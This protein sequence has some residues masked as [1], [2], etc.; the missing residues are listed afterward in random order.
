MS[1]EKIHAMII[2]VSR[3]QLWDKVVLSHM[4]VWQQKN[5]YLIK[6]DEILYILKTKTRK[7]TNSGSVYH[8]GASCG[9][10]Y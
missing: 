3:I 9:L 7:R 5:C 1:S 10:K 6:T 8:N 2:L 4:S